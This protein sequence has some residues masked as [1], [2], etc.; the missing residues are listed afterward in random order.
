MVK[1]LDTFTRSLGVSKLLQKARELSVLG[2][3]LGSSPIFVTHLWRCSLAYPKW[4]FM[5]LFISSVGV[6]R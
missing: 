5:L 2:A 6:R 4:V 3:A 1:W